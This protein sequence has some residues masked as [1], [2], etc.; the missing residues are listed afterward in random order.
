MIVEFKRILEVLDSVGVEEVIFD[1]TEEGTL[2]RATDKK[3]SIVVFDEIDEQFSDSP[4]GVQSVRGLLSRINLFDVEKST[5]DLDEG[6]NYILNILI[7][8]GRKKASFRC[9]P[10]KRI[11]APPSAPDSVWSDDIEFDSDYVG[12]LN[13]AITAM[14]FTGNKEER[15]IT[16]NGGSDGMRITISD[17]EDDSF[18]ELLPE[19]TAEITPGAWEVAPFQRAMLKAAE[20]SGSTKFRVDNYGIACFN[21]CHLSVM[22]VPMA[23]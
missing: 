13:K 8:Q 16:L 3:G 6:S 23:S 2:V 1:P 17:G 7:K 9:A 4:I 12:Y 15:K 22:I 10:P 21:L 5:I 20:Y 14:G 11:L 19:I 18:D